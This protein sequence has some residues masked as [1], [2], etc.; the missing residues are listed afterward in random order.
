VAADYTGAT[1]MAVGRLAA[2]GHRAVAYLGSGLD[3]EHVL[4]REAG[5]RQACQAYELDTNPRLHVS[6]ARSL[7]LDELRMLLGLG[8]TAF[9]TEDD[10]ILR[11]FQELATAMGLR[12]PG[13]VS[14]VTLV[15]PS[16][17]R[18]EATDVSGLRVPRLEMGD[19]AVR[20]LGELLEGTGGAGVRRLVLP[21]DVVAGATTGPPPRQK[22]EVQP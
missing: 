21:C 10:G 12:V 7:G 2:L 9:L 6:P 11:R 15:D 20:M 22:R 17:A 16:P 14:V 18:P 19:A 8:A 13:D 5:Y 3:A 4:D 1:A